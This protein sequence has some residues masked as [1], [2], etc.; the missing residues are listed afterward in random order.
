MAVVPSESVGGPVGAEFG[1]QVAGLWYRVEHAGPRRDG[2]PQLPVG[3][4]VVVA[5]DRG[6]VSGVLSVCFRQY[7]NGGMMMRACF[8]AVLG[9][10]SFVPLMPTVAYT[11]GW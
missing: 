5:G 4:T 11:C 8:G 2:R 6:S 7:S 3:A 10:E 9:L 1:V